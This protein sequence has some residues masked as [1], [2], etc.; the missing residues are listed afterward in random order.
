MISTRWRALC[1]FSPSLSPSPSSSLLTKSLLTKCCWLAGAVLLIIPIYTPAAQTPSQP[2]ELVETSDVPAAGRTIHVPAG[3][4]LQA[5]LNLAQPGDVITLAMGKTF[6][7]PFTLPNK[8]GNGWIVVRSSAPNRSLPPQGTRITPAY[9]SVLPKI[10]SDGVRPAL[11][12]APGA[13]HFRFVGVEFTVAANASSTDGLI[14]LGAGS[15]P[16]GSLDQ[17]PHHLTF[18]RVYVHGSAKGAL[19]RGFALNSAWTA[20][21]NSYISDVHEVGTDS[22]AIVGW[23]GPG[24]FKIVNNY[25]EAAG[26]NVM[27]GGA[28][29]AIA[30]LVPSDIEIRRNHFFKLLSWRRGEPGYAGTPWTVK[31]H[32]ELRNARRVLIDGNLFEQTWQDGR[33]GAS[34]V[35]AVRNENGGAPWST[36]EDVAFTNN[37]VRHAGAGIAMYGWDDTFPSR[38]THRILI[39]NNLFDDVS[40]ARWGGSG[41]LFQAL[42]GIDDLVI[43]HNTGFQDGSIGFADG[44]KHTRFIY[45][46]NLSTHSLYGVH[47]AATGTG[48]ETLTTYFPDSVFERNVL[49]GGTA[50]LYP[51]NNF[52][53]SSLDEVG[54]VDFARRNYRLSD[55]SP[56]K[57][58]GTDG[59]DIGADLDAIDAALAG[60]K[61]RTIAPAAAATSAATPAASVPTMAGLAMDSVSA[62]AT[63]GSLRVSPQDT[64]LNI[65]ATNYSA[66]TTLT[67]YTWPNFQVANAIV[68]K[69]DLT[70]IP[71]GAVVQ[72]ATLRLSLVESDGTTDPTYTVTAHK[73]LGKNPVIGTTTGY[74]TDGVTAW[75]P[76]ACC[77]NNVP[78]AQA[79]ISP[80]YDTRAIDK[81]LGD[82]AWTITAMVQEWQANP[83]TNFGLLLNSDPSKQ[84]DRYRFFASMEN[85][86]TTIRPF[87]DI[88]YSLPST[89]AGLV[90]AYSF[91]EG[92]GA[93]A[94]DA[95]GSG[96]TGTTSGATW[97]TAGRFGQALSFD[98]VNDWVTVADSNS[99]DLTTGMT[100]EAWVNP[101]AMSSWRTALVKER[102]GSGDLAY[103]LYAHNNDPNPAVTINVAGA[104]Y[105]SPGTS[106]V[107]LN[108]WTHLAA[109]YDGATLRLFVNAQQ[110]SSQAV[111]GAMVNSTSPLRIGGNAVWGEYFQGRIDEVRLYNR[112]LTSTEIQ[113][114][115]NAPVGNP[116]TDTTPPAVSISGPAA[117]STVSNTVTVAATASDNIAV[118]G[119]QFKL[120][121][122]VNLG[123]EDT[124]SPYSVSWNTTT[125]TNGSHTLTAAARDGAGN[126]TTSAGVNV[127]VTNDTT[128]PSV[129]IS[130]PT[131][132]AT[133][134][135]TV[136]VT[137]TASDNV[138]VLGVQ[139]KLDGV[140]LGAEDATSPYSTS[141]NTTTTSNGSHTLTAV[142]RDAAG[143]QKTSGG[144]TV[145]VSN[146]LPPPPPPGGVIF[147]SN[148]DTASG[149]SRNAVTDGGRWPNYWEFNNGSSVQLLSVVSGGANGHN[150]L[151]VQQRGSTYAANLQLDNFKAQSTDYY[152][153]Y[154]MKNDDTSS[155]GDHVVTT[156]TWEFWNLTYMRKMGGTSSW[157]FVISMY[158]CGYTYPISHWGP[159]L[160]LSNGQ[161]YRFEY[162][163]HYT[164]TN[165][166][167]VHPRVYDAAGNLILSDANFQQSDFGSA[168][169]NGRNDWTLASY[170]AAGH[171]FCV[172]PTYTNDFGLGNNGQYGAADTGRYWYYS[173]LQIR[174][175]TW[176]GPSGGSSGDTV[177]PGVSMTAPASG[178]TV[179]GTA[180]TVS[181]TASDNVGVAGVQFKLAGNNLGTEDT[182]SPYSISWNTTTTTDGNHTLTAVARDAAGNQTTSGGRTVTVSNSGPPPP[183]GG[184]AALYPGDTGIENHPDVVFVEKF[185]E[186]TTADLYARWTDVLNGSAMSFNSDVVPG[187]TGS[188]SL[189]IPW[190]G[191]GVSNGGHL[192]KLFSPGIDDTLYVRYYIKYPTSGQY[193]HDGLWMGGYNPPLT[194]PNPRA[195]IK[196]VGNDR[197]AAAAEQ[198]DDSSHFDHYNYWMNM[199]ISGDGNY[200]G[201]TLLN[202]PNV[203]ATEGQ[204]VCVEHMVK[205]NNPVTAFNGEHAIWLDGIKVSHLGQGFPNGTW[206]G[207]N[208]TQNPNGSPF[209][210]FRWRSDANLDLNWIWLQ[211]YSPDDPAGFT[212]SMKFDHVV[213]ARSYIGCLA[214]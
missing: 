200:W 195:G 138:G 184:I 169:W 6:I 140:N 153:R 178:A 38:L 75:T 85:S 25:L 7:G 115:M 109:T 94:T 201:N 95:S 149:T 196:P 32:F 193:R 102:S 130:A 209:E 50:G 161:W 132:G 13:H 108:T 12:T 33:D 18:D 156:D 154:Y 80:A 202:N 145:T 28:D 117:G 23:N 148:W 22:Q 207:G 170:Y 126:V 137:A 81:V 89:P 55:L 59:K 17:V 64:S 39:K 34:I 189:N 179:S 197:F 103:G 151:R 213:V 4:D 16:Q 129:S 83:A 128:L 66:D 35:F 160:A 96:N 49:V 106:Q 100:L 162:Y 210:G 131:A 173:A 104:Y 208:F 123:A 152:V 134:S 27:F 90:A 168:S 45:R 56:H 91:D 172:N 21:I 62:A 8:A 192:Y 166:I 150:A 177:A 65:N 114:D 142:A 122:V 61:P 204:W 158:G 2:L 146:T 99:L 30:D 46:N 98:G 20:I 3:G 44:G 186:P 135:S 73:I 57:N 176:P 42:K 41:Q 188:K 84:S 125:A 181:A 182:T 43:D 214:P 185:E 120:D 157:R 31:N 63:T 121:G 175:D 19:R 183:G 171:D 40:S 14:E 68:M 110:V 88:T 9:K 70:G 190:T 141:W 174:N 147:E 211:N 191:G 133:V 203:K 127:T 69:F 97:T 139:F 26:E 67:T 144:V 60:R 71:A 165:H 119:V 167:Q 124:T 155:A 52:F 187:S 199:R 92:T 74:T 48:L 72:T 37:I 24:P 194:Y 86:V 93:T 78:L 58:R 29:P 198:S 205:L 11:D 10:V 1:S 51:T 180:T 212:G 87:L 76:N 105:E 116:P 113:T 79:N 111:T 5:A 143:N 53:P 206:S 112:A 101:A 36:V 164:N 82:K 15:S 159:P 54:F 118:G 136:T 163:V 107:P 77:Y 47:G